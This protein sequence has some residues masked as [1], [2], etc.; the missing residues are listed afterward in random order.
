[1]KRILLLLLAALC[2]AA[3]L[4]AAS[5]E[6]Q[7]VLQEAD[8]AYREAQYQAAQDGYL[9]LL[10]NEGATGHL[11]Y[12]L[13]NTAFR[14]NQTGR[15]ILYYEKARLLLPRDADLLYNLGRARE[16]ARDATPEPTGFAA[17]AFFWIG[18][19]TLA[20]IFWFFAAANVLFWALMLL[21]L[22]V[23]AEWTH[24]LLYLF[25]TV[26]LLAGASFWMKWH[27]VRT[28]D[29]AVILQAEVGVLAGPDIRDTLLFK[30]HEGTIVRQERAEEGWSLIRLP[31][32]K[33]GWM[34]SEALERVVEGT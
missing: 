24:Y 3:P 12:N 20:E 10:R 14:L 25:L 30:L 27:Q 19:L 33:R 15:A 32:G 16:L 5:P 26:W 23:K 13:G 1:M 17:A 31:D 21:R 6:S 11:L 9:R 22:S 8:R 28:D 2:V 34:K 7:R 29:R 4:L 18:S